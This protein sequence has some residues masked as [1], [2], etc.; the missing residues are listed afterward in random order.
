MFKHSICSNYY[1]MGK[2]HKHGNAKCNMPLTE[3][4]KIGSSKFNI[5]SWNKNILFFSWY[6]R[7]CILWLLHFSGRACHNNCSIHINTSYKGSSTFA[8]FV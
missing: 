3:Y 4:F 6:L 8:C 5:S 2:P 7:Q 1:K